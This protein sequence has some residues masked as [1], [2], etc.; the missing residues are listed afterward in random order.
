MFTEVL[1]VCV[2]NLCNKV[3]GQRTENVVFYLKMCVDYYRYLSEFRQDA[4]YNN[5]SKQ[6]YAKALDIADEALCATNP[7]K[8]GLALNFSVNIYEN[9]KDPQEAC[10]FA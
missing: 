9:L 8:L 1:Y 2:N 4:R 6:Y 7:T 10:Y 3:E 5:S